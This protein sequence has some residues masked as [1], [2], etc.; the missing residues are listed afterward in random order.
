MI[1]LGCAGC[2]PDTIEVEITVCPAPQAAF[3]LVVI[4]TCSPGEIFIQNMTDFDNN[5]C[6]VDQF[7]WLL[8]DGT[9]IDDALY[10]GFTFS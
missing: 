9:V 4:D 1:A 7:L 5:F 10:D 2:P 6:L 3:E 8:G